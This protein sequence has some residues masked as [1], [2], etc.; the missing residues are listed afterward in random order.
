[1]EKEIFV[2]SLAT[3]ERSRNP[4]LNSWSSCG[5]RDREG[6][7]LPQWLPFLNEPAG[8]LLHLFARKPVFQTEQAVLKDLRVHDFYFRTD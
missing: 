8:I 2:Q 3:F 5:T 4:R 6:A 1:M 7:I